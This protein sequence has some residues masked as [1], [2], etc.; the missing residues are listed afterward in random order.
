VALA[1][2]RLLAAAPRLTPAQVDAAHAVLDVLE[3]DAERLHVMAA[4]EARDA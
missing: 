1:R 2:K 3:Q 4:E